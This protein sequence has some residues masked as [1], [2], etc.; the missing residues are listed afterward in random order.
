MSGLNIGGFGV[1]PSPVGE[2][3]RAMVVRLFTVL[4]NS[5][6][7]MRATVEAGGSIYDAATAMNVALG[8]PEMVAR[9]LASQWMVAHGITDHVL[10]PASGGRVQ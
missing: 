9:Q 8:H 10:A 1:L 6:R 7:A 2:A 4:E 5:A 3:Q